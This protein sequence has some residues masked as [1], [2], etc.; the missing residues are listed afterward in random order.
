[1]LTNCPMKI[2]ISQAQNNW[3]VL[4]EALVYKRGVHTKKQI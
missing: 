1:M 2:K 4:K 3:S